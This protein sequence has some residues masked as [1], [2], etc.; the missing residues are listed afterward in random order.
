MESPFVHCPN[1][2]GLARAVGSMSRISKRRT[3]WT[4]ARNRLLQL[5]FFSKLSVFFFSPSFF[6]LFSLFSFSACE[7]TTWLL[8]RTNATVDEQVCIYADRLFSN[9][10]QF[11]LIISLLLGRRSLIALYKRDKFSFR[12]C[13]F[14]RY[15]FFFLTQRDIHSIFFFAALNAFP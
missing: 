5:F 7:R 4:R 3:L 11:A 13:F 15:F 9:R 2:P 14:C 10:V 12:S 6:P 1:A 8:L